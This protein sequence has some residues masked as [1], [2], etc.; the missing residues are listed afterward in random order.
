[1]SA[2][3]RMTTPGS[4]DD[5]KVH[6]YNA[7]TDQWDL[8]RTCPD[9]YKSGYVLTSGTLHTNTQ[10]GT[11]AE[12][13]LHVFPMQLGRRMSFDRLYVFA[14]V[15]GSTGA[16]VRMVAYAHTNGMPGALLADT[17][18]IA[19]TGTG[20]LGE[21]AAVSFSA[22]PGVVW[23]GTVV[24]GAAVTRPQL[25][26]GIDQGINLPLPIEVASINQYGASGY[27]ADIGTGSPPS[28][29]SSSP[30]PIGQ[31]AVVWARMV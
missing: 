23:L 26:V 20:A 6:V 15:G 12:G 2:S 14:T 16:V 8:G 3:A 28:S 1:M 9:F 13:R 5:S 4:S 11:L 29:W 17:G 27:Y 7:T 30:S 24:Q 10:A 25:L 19:A 22:G 31:M 21:S 18:Q